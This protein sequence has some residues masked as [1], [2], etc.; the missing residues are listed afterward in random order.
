MPTANN[1]GEETEA[2]FRISWCGTW[3]RKGKEKR[4]SA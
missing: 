4:Y 3:R 1:W 2:E